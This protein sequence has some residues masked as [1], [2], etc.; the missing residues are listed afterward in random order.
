VFEV[1]DLVVKFF[2]EKEVGRNGWI[3]FGVCEG[4]DV[5]WYLGFGFGL[6]VKFWYG[7]FLGVILVLDDVCCELDCF[8]DCDVGYVGDGYCV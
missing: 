8:F 6:V 3:G 5:E 1:C 7:L 2:V 4:W